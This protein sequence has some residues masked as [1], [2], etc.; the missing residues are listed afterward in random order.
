MHRK[1]SLPATKMAE[2]SAKKLP[3]DRKANFT[4]IEANLI[5]SR[6]THELELLKGGFSPEVTNQK[7]NEL[8]KVITEEV[9]ALGVCM[10]SET[11]VRNKYRNMCRGAKEKF[12]N[13]RKEMSKTGGGPPPTQLTIAEENIVNAMR[14]SASFIGVGGLETEIT[15]NVMQGDTGVIIID[16]FKEPSKVEGKVNQKNESRSD[17]HDDQLQPNTPTENVLRNDDVLNCHEEGCTRVFKTFSG[18]EAHQVF[19]TEEELFE[20][21]SDE[22]VNDDEAAHISLAV[23]TVEAV[24]EVD[25]YLACPIASCNN[26]KMVT[27]KGEDDIYRMNCKKCHGTFRASS[28]NKYMRAV[29]LLKTDSDLKKVVMFSP[30]IHKMFVSRGLDCTIL[31]EKIDMVKIFLTI[32]PVEIRYRLVNNTVRELVCKRVY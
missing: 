9:N 14:D 30:Q 17:H 23:G 7:K 1:S 10:R 29:V 26:V 27:V 4:S 16:D 8:W 15:C 25:P 31:F 12:T 28:C 18:L 11:E 19:V 24:V 3:R 2:L 21:S 20:V 32:L 22:E 13:N 5:S 6:V